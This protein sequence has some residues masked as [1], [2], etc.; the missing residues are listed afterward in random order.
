MSKKI[1]LEAAVRILA[2]AAHL[3]ADQ[4]AALATAL[5]DDHKDDE[6]EDDGEKKGKK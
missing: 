3:R 2:D 1:D 4:K 6:V 5:G